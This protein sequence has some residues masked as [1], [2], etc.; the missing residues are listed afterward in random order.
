MKRTTEGTDANRGKRI[1]TTTTAASAPPP[2]PPP[3]PSSST[4]SKPRLVKNVKVAAT[5]AEDEDD[6]KSTEDVAGD[7][8]TTEYS[9]ETSTSTGGG[10]GGDDTRESGQDAEDSTFSDAA[11]AA[12]AATSADTLL[13]DNDRAVLEADPTHEPDPEAEAEV[14]ENS[15]QENGGGVEEDAAT[16]AEEVTPTEETLPPRP[17]ASSRSKI[18]MVTPGT[19]VMAKKAAS[20]RHPGNGSVSYS[21]SAASSMI[22]AGQGRGGRGGGGVHARGGGGYS[23]GGGGSIVRGRGGVGGGMSMVSGG[24]GRGVGGGGGG[25]GGVGRGSMGGGGGGRGGRG[26]RGMG[27]P[28]APVYSGG[29]GGGGMGYGGVGGG[30]G[31]GFEWEG[32]HV[33]PNEGIQDEEANIITSFVPLNE[34]EPFNIKVEYPTKVVPYKVLYTVDEML[35]KDVWLNLRWNPYIKTLNSTYKMAMG[36]MENSPKRREPLQFE[37]QEATVEWGMKYDEGKRDSSRPEITFG[38]TVAEG[39][40]LFKAL[41]TGQIALG[42]GMVWALTSLLPTRDPRELLYKFKRTLMAKKAYFTK[43]GRP[44]TGTL[45]IHV[46]IEARQ[47]GKK[48]IPIRN[49]ENN[50]PLIASSCNLIWERNTPMQPWMWYK[51]A[52]KEVPNPFICDLSVKLDR[53]YVSDTDM[54]YWG[55]RFTGTTIRIL[56][57]PQDVTQKQPPPSLSD[58]NDEEAWQ[59]RQE[60]IAGFLA[61]Q[62]ETQDMPLL[63]HENTSGGDGGGGGG[64]GDETHGDLKDE[65]KIKSTTLSSF[66][67]TSTVKVHP[68]KKSDYSIKTTLPP[69]SSPHTIRS[70]TSTEDTA[71]TTSSD[72]TE[73]SSSL[74]RFSPQPTAPTSYDKGLN[75]ADGGSGSHEL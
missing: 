3:P 69:F 18:P 72:Y 25:G 50:I 67:P 51:Y 74:N 71:T 17:T 22:V 37:I 49:K 70:V 4:R 56:T 23:R 60:R 32:G 15:T 8:G 20:I 5:V 55:A 30:G 45:T 64:G 24:Y 42:P 9:E 21:S 33:I 31:G 66:P 44:A 6:K 73:V 53:C 57:P 59:R 12:A 28:M 7:H 62:R 35:D 47:E 1:K 58:Q 36:Y 41:E 43:T 14:E 65:T 63:T 38:V 52:Q 39:T 34:V 48:W 16:A 61:L 68:P 11:I 10:G 54:N 2:P 46:P 27:I 29:G 26:G 75:Q 40:P 19:L 13:D